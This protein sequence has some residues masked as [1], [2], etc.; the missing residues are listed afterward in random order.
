MQYR[1]LAFGLLASTIVMSNAY[2]IGSVSGPNVTE[3]E[4]ELE[5]QGEWHHDDKDKAS[6]NEQEHVFAVG[7][8]F[9]EKWAFELEGE[10]IRESRD[11]FDLEQ[12][13]IEF[14]RQLTDIGQFWWDLGARGIYNHTVDSGAADSI[15]FRLLTENN[16]D[17]FRTRVNLNVSTSWDSR[18]RIQ[19]SRSA[20]TLD[21]TGCMPSSLPLSSNQILVPLTTWVVLMSS[22]TIWARWPMATSPLWKQ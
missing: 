19:N 11:A 9:A 4:L 21:T 16:T 22:H 10:F 3:G 8:G 6:K 2:A 20:P 15:E 17:H 7:Y 14:T 1:S 5:Y 12:I 18:A 13:E